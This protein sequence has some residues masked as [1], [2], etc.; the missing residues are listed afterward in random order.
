MPDIKSVLDNTDMSIAMGVDD[1]RVVKIAKLAIIMASSDTD[2]RDKYLS[3]KLAIKQ[4][5]LTEDE[6]AALLAYRLDLEDFAAE[7]RILE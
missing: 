3:I 1:P 4:G 7:V 5:V 2:L 6:G